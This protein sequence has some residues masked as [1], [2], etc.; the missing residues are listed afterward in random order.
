MRTRTTKYLRLTSTWLLADNSDAVVTFFFDVPQ[1][2]K[3]WSARLKL[4]HDELLL[5]RFRSCKAKFEEELREK[6]RQAEEDIIA[7][8]A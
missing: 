2:E 7:V 8:S 6:K 1:L 3:A 5:L 4:L